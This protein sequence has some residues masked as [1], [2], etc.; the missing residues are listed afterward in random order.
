MGS[1]LQFAATLCE[2]LRHEP[3]LDKSLSI[4]GRKASSPW[5]ENPYH[6]WKEALVAGGRKHLSPLE[7]NPRC[8]CYS[9][10]PCAIS[11]GWN[12]IRNSRSFVGCKK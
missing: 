4:V 2:Q 6:Q 1:G 10:K 3:H 11:G 7:G 12:L 5:L 8:T 9:L